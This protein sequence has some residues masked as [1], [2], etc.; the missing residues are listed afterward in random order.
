M[1]KSIKI[2]TL[3][4]IAL[5]F[6][7]FLTSCESKKIETFGFKETSY[8]IKVEERI[9]VELTL[10]EK[11][12]KDNIEY[13]SSNPE[14]ATFAKGVLK[15][16]GVGETTITISYKDEDND[17]S[18]SISVKVDLSVEEQ[19]L[20]DEAKAFDAKVE[21]WT[22]VTSQDVD[23]LKALVDEL[24]K[25]LNV[26]AL[27]YVT[28]AEEL[29]TMY[30]KARAL[31]VD[32]MIEALPEV[33]AP[34]H[35]E[36]V[37]AARLAYKTCV[38]G[39]K[40]QVTKLEVLEAK[41]KAL[42]EA[43]WEATPDVVTLTYQDKSYMKVNEELIILVETYKN[44]PDTVIVWTSSDKKV[45]TVTDGVVT[46]KGTG[47]AIITATI[48]GT[49]YTMSLG[50]NVIASD[51]SEL[52]ELI[53]KSH[54]NQVFYRPQLVVAPGDKAQYYTDILG[55]VSDL[56]FNYNYY[57]DEMFLNQAIS[58]GT[59]NKNELK[60]N[61]IEFI[62]VHY[63]GN[64]APTSDADNNASYFAGSSLV[65]IH[66]VTGTGG[67]MNNQPASDIYKV[68]R[69]EDGGYH[70]GDS[71]AKGLVGEFEWKKTGVKYDNA[72]LL[73]GV[74]VTI[75]D[76]FYYEINGQKTPI[77]M[78]LP[79]DYENRGTDY[80]LNADGTLATPAFTTITKFTN[81]T[82][83]SF[84]NQQGLPLTIIDGEYYMGTT[85]WCYTQAQEGRICGTGGNRNSLGIE[86]CVNKGS[87]LWK[88]WHVTAQLVAH[89]MEE[90]GLDITR[91]KGHRFYS[92]KNCPQPMLMNN[93]EIWWEFIDMVQ[94]EY[95]LLT[96]YPK[97][98]ISFES[99][100]PE[101]VDNFGRVIKN[102]TEDVTV[103]Y[104]LTI[105]NA[106]KTEKITLYS[107]IAGSG[108]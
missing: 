78:P 90:T 32:E 49:E 42:E 106:G 81:R 79:Y 100:N 108:K 6:G 95:E 69:H 24:N 86:S 93:M 5:V 88:T 12:I 98:E 97:C 64:M 46:G 85:W 75:S 58:T 55:S 80:V 19:A 89:L 18:K 76:D 67:M 22:T 7:L 51:S 87:D 57:V 4:V 3:F 47:S 20:Y 91:V 62:T 43:I 54:N 1:Q 25:D 103:S 65:S 34:E 104:T 82:P 71:S 16:T 44:D 53:I 8:T 31:V 105:K 17:L 96:K 66:Y 37:K 14:I 38:A 59:Y 36:L 83:E 99:H 2:F 77:P 73:K 15:G 74:E 40:K 33:I 102:A 45:A 29:E 68:L 101:Y 107:V 11:V 41:E 26:D 28:K 13:S 92:G 48:E 35:E 72:D 30:D 94:A 60:D 27:K 39:V 61:G 10:D 21:A 50:V 23:A 56:L 63:T 70:A 84:I 9:V 52:L